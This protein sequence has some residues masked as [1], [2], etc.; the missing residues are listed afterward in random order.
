MDSK[1]GEMEESSGK[2]Y[3]TIVLIYEILFFF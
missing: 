2:S 1:G 3:V